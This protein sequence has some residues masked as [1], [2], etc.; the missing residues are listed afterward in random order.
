MRQ[1]PGLPLVDEI[2]QP[3]DVV[4]LVHEPVSVVVEAVQPVLVGQPVPV[5]VG[6][7]GAVRIAVQQVLDCVPDRLARDVLP[8]IDLGEDQRL[9][10]VLVHR[11]VVGHLQDGDVTSLPGGPDDVALRDGGMR[12]LDVRH[13]V[14]HLGHVGVVPLGTP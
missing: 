5:L 2:P 3:G 14:R 9:G 12:R 4:V 7:H 11:H 8:G 6:A 1:E 13:P 10:L